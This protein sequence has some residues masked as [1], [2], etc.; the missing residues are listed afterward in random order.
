ML[1]CNL[2]LKSDGRWSQRCPIIYKDTHPPLFPSSCSTIWPLHK[3]YSH[4]LVMIKNYMLHKRPTSIFFP[5]FVS[6]SYAP[7]PAGIYILHIEVVIL[8]HFH[9]PESYLGNSFP[10]INYV[11]QT[12]HHTL[13]SHFFRSEISLEMRRN[14]FRI[15][16]SLWTQK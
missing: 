15:K 8:H 6:S 11:A 1:N 2:F 16:W 5:L 12:G 4:L 9:R 14:A 10:I 3:D 7:S 13:H